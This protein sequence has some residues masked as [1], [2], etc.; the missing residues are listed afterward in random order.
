MNTKYLSTIVTYLQKFTE[1]LSKETIHPM[2]VYYKKLYL[3]V[4]QL[5]LLNEY[6]FIMKIISSYWLFLKSLWDIVANMKWNECV[7]VTV[8]LLLIVT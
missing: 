8:Y 2:L 6:N 1:A 3:F 4:E 7:K 5:Q